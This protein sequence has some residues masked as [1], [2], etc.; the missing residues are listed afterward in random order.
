M[1][2][3]LP[4]ILRSLVLCCHFHL[5]VTC[6]KSKGFLVN[7]DAITFEKK[8]TNWSK[9]H[10]FLNLLFHGEPRCWHDCAKASNSSGQRPSCITHTNPLFSPLRSLLPYLL[11]QA[12][13]SPQVLVLT[14]LS[15][16]NA[17]LPSLPGCILFILQILR[18]LLECPHCPPISSLPPDPIWIQCLSSL[19]SIPPVTTEQYVL[20]FIP[21]YTHPR[22]ST[23][24]YL[25]ISKHKP[26]TWQVSLN[27][28]M[29][30]CF[31][32]VSNS[33]RSIYWASTTCQESNIYHY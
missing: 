15:A 24:L 5:P 10:Y 31:S 26:G 2:E 30:G 11:C 33:W 28:I 25:P 32:T 21:H 4:F 3:Y 17:F 6:N 23:C 18:S 7:N 9:V 14:G 27:S 22:H 19:F 29:V 13:C 12:F 16:W 1:F 20:V 8:R